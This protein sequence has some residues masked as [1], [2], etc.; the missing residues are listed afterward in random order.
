MLRVVLQARKHIGIVSLWFLLLHVLMSMAILSPAYY[1]KF[2]EMNEYTPYAKMNAVGE[3]SLCFGV[4]GTSL[5][6]I[7]GVASLHSVAS[8]MNMAQ[9]DLIYGAVAWGALLCGV[10]HVLIMGVQGWTAVDKW[11]GGLPP[12]TM[13]STIFPMAVIGLKLTQVLIMRQFT[14]WADFVNWFRMKGVRQEQQGKLDKSHHASRDCNVDFTATGA[15]SDTGDE[16][17]VVDHF[18]NDDDVG[19]KH[20]S[21]LVNGGCTDDVIGSV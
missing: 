5:Y 15:V 6:A 13:T 14:L 10:M 16:L 17:A 4:L 18:D 9:W 8:N 1:S 2:Y 3:F 21:F 12:I 11:P 20:R 19:F 7:M